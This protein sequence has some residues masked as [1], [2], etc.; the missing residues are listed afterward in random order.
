MVKFKALWAYLLFR[1]GQYKGYKMILAISVEVWILSAIINSLY[2]H[3]CKVLDLK[4]LEKNTCSIYV[5]RPV[6]DFLY[7]QSMWFQSNER[8]YDAITFGN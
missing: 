1:Y 8:I 6:T 2:C 3:I 4:L 7:L 5:R